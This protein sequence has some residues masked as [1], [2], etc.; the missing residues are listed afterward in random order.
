M[1]KTLSILLLLQPSPVPSPLPLPPVSIIHIPR[2][3]ISPYTIP[4]LIIMHIWRRF[5]AMDFVDTLDPVVD[6]FGSIFRTLQ[7]SYSL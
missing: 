1:I 4:I 3:L 5:G 7:T 2:Q 6:R